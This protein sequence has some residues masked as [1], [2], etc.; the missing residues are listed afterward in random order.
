MTDTQATDIVTFD[1][2]GT[3]VRCVVCGTIDYKMNFFLVHNV[4]NCSRFVI[5]IVFLQKKKQI[6]PPLRNQKNQNI[7]K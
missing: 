7:T 5:R 4:A 3:G 6:S 1:F 2:E